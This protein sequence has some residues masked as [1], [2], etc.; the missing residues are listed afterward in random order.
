MDPPLASDM[1]CN[2]IALFLAGV[3]A[4]NH[5]CLPGQEAVLCLFASFV[6]FGDQD[7]NFQKDTQVTMSFTSRCTE[8]SVTAMRMR[9]LFTNA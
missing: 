3:Q 8:A 9:R 2:C 7:V 6:L 5:M 4:L 1:A